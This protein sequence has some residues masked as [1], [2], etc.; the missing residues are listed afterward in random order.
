MAKNLEKLEKELLEKKRKAMRKM[1]EGH[2][3]MINN[4]KEVD[5]F[6]DMFED[7]ERFLKEG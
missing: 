7:Y 5:E 6:I 2:N 3:W 1:L 4:E